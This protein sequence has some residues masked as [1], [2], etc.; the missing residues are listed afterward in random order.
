[1]GTTNRMMA[2]AMIWLAAV[3]AWGQQS[4]DPPQVTSDN[5]VEQSL[6]AAEGAGQPACAICGMCDSRPL[7]Y[8]P[9][10]DPPIESRSTCYLPCD[11]CCGPCNHCPGTSDG[12]C[13]RLRDCFCRCCCGSFGYA[14]YGGPRM[15]AN[16]CDG[17]E[18]P[19]FVGPSCEQCNYC[20]D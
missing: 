7:T 6:V 9:M 1:M 15:R 20:N 19:L 12:W 5:A 2:T 4:T 18:P 13:D 10:F 17:C 3:A 8:K 16:C 14:A 11:R